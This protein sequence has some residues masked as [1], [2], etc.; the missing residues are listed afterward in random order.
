VAERVEFEGASGQRLVGLLDLPEGDPTACALFAHC[1]TCGKD[2]IAASRIARALTRRGLAVLRYDVTGLGESEGEFGAATFTSDVSDLAAAADYLASRGKGPSLLVGHSIGGAA[3]LAAAS[4]IPEVRAVVTIGAP[5]DPAH[6]T[7]LFGE[8]IPDLEA[9]GRAEVTLAGRTFTISKSFLE[10]IRSQSLHHRIAELG[11]A[12]L[13]LHSPQDQIVPIENAREIYE[14]ARH[15]KSFVALDGV[16]HLI[17]KR[18]DAEYVAEVLTAWSSR[19]LPAVGGRSRAAGTAAA[20]TED[21][22]SAV[23]GAG[24]D[25]LAPGEVRVVDTG[26]GSFEQHVRAGRHTWTSDEPLDAGGGDTGPG[27]YDLLLAALGTCTSMTM[28]MYARRKQW[29]LAGIQVVLHQDRVHGD[30]SDSCDARDDG[31]LSRIRREITLEGELTG[32]QRRAILGIADKC[33]V[34]RTLV[35]EVVIETTEA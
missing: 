18:E 33:P 15:P 30:D 2:N 25:A 32:D 3:V 8:V 26:H 28:R 11:C 12:L 1:F 35:Q 24:G 10:D 4:E 27:P 6:V 29:N 13:V 17:S 14:A 7:D 20:E 23:K 19:Y 31:C 21:G 16:D 34:H 9:T 22:S 5:S